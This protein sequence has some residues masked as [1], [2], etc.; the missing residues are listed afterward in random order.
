VLI[1]TTLV[2]WLAGDRW[3]LTVPLLYGPRWVLSG[4]LL[5]IAPLLLA[6]PRRGVPVLLAA[7]ALLWFGVLGA[8]PGVGR[9]FGSDDGLSLRVVTF[10]LRVGNDQDPAI[11]H[12]LADV[13][14]DVAILT[15]CRRER[16]E[17]IAEIA[18]RNVRTA[19]GLC[20][21][22]RLKIDSIAARDPRE[23]WKDYGSGA[24]V[25]ATVHHPIAGPLQVGMVHLATPRHVLDHFFD[26]SS[27]PTLGDTVGQNIALR[28]R[29]S[30]AARE[31]IGD[32]TGVDLIAGDFNLPVE[33]AIYRRHWGDYANA[34]SRAGWGLGRTKHTRLIGVRIDHIL[35]G[36]RV[37]ARR[38][39]VGPALGS[40][41][42]PVIAELKLRD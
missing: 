3:W 16:G 20:L 1:A 18:R 26:L 23:F 17:A 27:I 9:W 12:W 14:P 15:E 7:L 19:S 33:S 2:L 28:D 34:F 29:E 40:D 8:V 6:Q 37:S 41:H 24:I 32:P 31:W 21:L 25:R 11:G 22:S 13:D 36:E 30:S 5:G 39:W 35:L 4:A 42:R 38:A 10:N